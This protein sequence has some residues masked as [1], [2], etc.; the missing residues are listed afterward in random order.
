MYKMWYRCIRFSTLADDI[1]LSLFNAIFLLILEVLFLIH[2]QPDDLGIS[3][4]AASSTSPAEHLSFVWPHSLL[5]NWKLSC[6]KNLD[7]LLSIH[8]RHHDPIS[9]RNSRNYF[10]NASK[11][12]THFFWS[13]TNITIKNDVFD[14]D[15]DITG[16]RHFDIFR[17][18]K[19]ML[20]QAFKMDIFQTWIL[21]Q[22][23]PAWSDP[24]NTT[25]L[26]TNPM[27]KITCQFCMDKK[28]V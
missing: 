4:L 3:L 28:V 13:I 17:I 7:P 6:L 15:L 16:S 12:S 19:I 24:H 2:L 23:W 22:F 21:C 11:I 5:G 27:S 26:T 14:V 8:H 25:L 18:K 10:L 1:S 20:K 9:C